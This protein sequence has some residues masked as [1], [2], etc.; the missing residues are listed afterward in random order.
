MQL[1]PILVLEILS[2]FLFSGRSPLSGK[3]I[4]WA[5]SMAM[6]CPSLGSCPRMQGSVSSRLAVSTL[7]LPLITLG[8]TAPAAR[9]PG[10]QISQPQGAP[11]H[12]SRGIFFHTFPSLGRSSEVSSRP[13]DARF[14]H[15]VPLPLSRPRQLWG[16]NSLTQVASV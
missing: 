8:E 7:P 13:N 10:L 3:S 14:H 16:Q 15:E 12:H 9:S 2:C 11:H 1:N 5:Q 6:T 4:V